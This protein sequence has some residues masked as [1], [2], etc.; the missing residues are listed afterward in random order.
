MSSF[1]A[2]GPLITPVLFIAFNRVQPARKVMEAIREAKPPRLYFACDG[3]RNEAE[4]NRC[5]EVRAL[6]SMVD[7]DCEVFTRFSDVNLGVMM[8]ESIAM[9]WFFENEEEGIILED[10][11]WPSQSFFWFCQELLERYRHDERVWCIMGNT[12]MGGSW[13]EDSYY[14]SAHGYGAYWG[15]AGWRRYGKSMM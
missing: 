12:M 10:D 1:P 6:V 13:E 2:P 14:F 7:W 15:W 5:E 4:R 3:P 8:G 11:T 9:D